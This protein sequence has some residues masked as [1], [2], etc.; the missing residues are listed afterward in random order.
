MADYHS[1]VWLVTTAPASA[2]EAFKHF[3]DHLIQDGPT[4]GTQ[5]LGY[6][7]LQKQSDGTYVGTSLYPDGTTLALSAGSMADGTLDSSRV[8]FCLRRNGNEVVRVDIDLQAKKPRDQVVHAHLY[9]RR[10]HIY[11]DGF[12]ELITNVEKIWAQEDSH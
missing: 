3:T 12:N 2:L 7:G 4:F 8:G 9:G 1:P 5:V 6:F 10:N 11:V